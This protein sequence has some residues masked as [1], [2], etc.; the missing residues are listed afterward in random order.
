[1]NN[2]YLYKISQK[3]A[4]KWL[5]LLFDVCIVIFTFF[6]AHLIKFNFTLNFDFLEILKQIPFVAITAA[7]CF[8][9]VGSHKGVV[10]YTGI[11]DVINVLIGV[12]HFSYSIINRNLFNKKFLFNI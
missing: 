11:K 8:L 12:N 7:I 5:V 4:S 1:M 10:R 2:K 9:I 6:L 3:Y